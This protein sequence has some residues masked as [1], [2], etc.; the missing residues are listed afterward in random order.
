MTNHTN[1]TIDLTPYINAE[2]DTVKTIVSTT[3]I[4]EETQTTGLLALQ[5]RTSQPNP[6]TIPFYQLVIDEFAQNTR[7]TTSQIQYLDAFEKA[8]AVF[9]STALELRK[10]M[11]VLS[12][13]N[14]E[15]QTSQTKLG[16]ASQAS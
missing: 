7:N 14:A 9:R 5:R 4:Q 12:N 11:G 8:V 15:Q 13:S 3:T 16:A 1:T 6:Q 2:Q 10:T